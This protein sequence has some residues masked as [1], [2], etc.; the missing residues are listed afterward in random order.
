MKKGLVFME[1]SCN[2]KIEN[3]KF[4]NVANEVKEL[5]RPFL[6]FKT[7]NIISLFYLPHSIKNRNVQTSVDNVVELCYGV[8]TE[9]QN[10]TKSI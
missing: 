5:S 6:L 9:Q 10:S 3:K 2:E 8:P 7:K 4:N 1:Y